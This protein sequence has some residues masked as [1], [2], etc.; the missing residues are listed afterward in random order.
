MIITLIICEISY[1]VTYLAEGIPEEK[2]DFYKRKN[3]FTIYLRNNIRFDFTIL[4]A[5][6]CKKRIGS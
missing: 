3:S 4:R 2:L 6:C 1:I 5:V